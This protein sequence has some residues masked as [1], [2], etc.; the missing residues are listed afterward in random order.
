MNEVNSDA[1]NHSIFFG[2]KETRL[3]G[4][5]TVYSSLRSR[6][7]VEFACRGIPVEEK[8]PIIEKP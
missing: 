7:G 4:V 5:A 8:V 6:K 1:Q 3:R 2:Q